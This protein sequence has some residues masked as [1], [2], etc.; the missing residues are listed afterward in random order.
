MISVY[1]DG[2]CSCNG[3]KDA[4]GGIGIYFGPEDPRNYSAT[5]SKF[6]NDT[7]AG[8][9]KNTNNLAELCAIFQ[10]CKILEKDLESGK[11]VLIL[12][13]S[14]YSINCLTVWYR[15]WIKNDWL[16]ASKNPVSNKIVIE[17]ILNDYLLKF[18]DSIK[19]KHVK[20]HTNLK[21]AEAEGNAAADTL[22]NAAT[23][24]FV[25]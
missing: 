19:F 23:K 4:V 6:Y 18:K 22:A 7:F 3:K 20:A 14:N 17:K 5:L 10:A 9:V 12:T 13:D 1:T 11:K 25:F 15:N 8:T 24:K 16:N 21:G 2:S